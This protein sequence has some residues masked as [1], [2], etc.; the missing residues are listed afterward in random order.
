MGLSKINKS[1]AYARAAQL[2]KESAK[3]TPDDALAG[4]TAQLYSQ[5]Q[6]A[7]QQVASL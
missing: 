5:L 7:Q 1:L 4:H 3:A 6:E 2:A